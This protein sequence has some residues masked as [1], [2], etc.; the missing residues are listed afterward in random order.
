MRLSLSEPG[1]GALPVLA[2]SAVAAAAHVVV[3]EQPQRLL[4]PRRTLL[5]LPA[6]SEAAPLCRTDGHL[7]SVNVWAAFDQPDILQSFCSAQ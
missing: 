1:L 2:L 7:H 4:M 3:S 5:A 6:A